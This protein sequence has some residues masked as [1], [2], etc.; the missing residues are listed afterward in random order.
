MTPQTSMPLA[1]RAGKVASLIELDGPRLLHW[2]GTGVVKAEWLVGGGAVTLTVAPG[3][4]RALLDAVIPRG[5][6]LRVLHGLPYERMLHEAIQHLERMGGAQ[7]LAGFTGENTVV[8]PSPRG[9]RRAVPE[10]VLAAVSH[11]YAEGAT[12]SA[13]AEDL[14]YSRQA[15]GTW[16]GRARARGYLADRVITPAARKVLG[17]RDARTIILEWSQRTLPASW[18]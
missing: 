6:P 8:R 2:F 1:T 3:E 7:V 10:D 4:D 15:V 16:V 13:L 12:Q 17:G 18:R 9:R 11:L 5:V 14:G